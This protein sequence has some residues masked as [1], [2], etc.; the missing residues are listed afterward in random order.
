MATAVGLIYVKAFY[1]LTKQQQS[2][3]SFPMPAPKRVAVTDE[4]FCLYGG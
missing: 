3:F 4:D 2:L 1:S